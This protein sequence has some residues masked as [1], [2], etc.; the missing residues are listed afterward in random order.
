MKKAKK[1]FAVVAATIMVLSMGMVSVNAAEV[2]PRAPI[3]PSCSSP[4]RINRTYGAWR[5]YENQS[6]NHGYPYGQDKVYHRTVLSQT[7]CTNSKCGLAYPEI[8][9]TESKRECHGY[10]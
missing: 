10:Y 3:C 2:Q 8:I 5:F 7:I 1:M 9:S 4:M 6:C